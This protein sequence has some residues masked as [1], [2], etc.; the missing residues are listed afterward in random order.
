MEVY[1]MFTKVFQP[2][3]LHT[4]AKNGE[5][6]EI[7]KLIKCNF[8]INAY[9]LNY[10]P[11]QYSLINLDEKKHLNCN[12]CAVILLENGAD[13]NAEYKFEYFHLKKIIQIFVWGGHLSKVRLLAIYGASGENIQFNPKQP[14]AEKIFKETEELYNLK[15]K[16]ETIIGQQ[17]ASKTETRQAY[18]GLYEIWHTLANKENDDVFKKHYQHKANFYLEFIHLPKEIISSIQTVSQE[19]YISLRQRNTKLSDEQQPLI[20]YQI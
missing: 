8:D 17:S 7:N 6:Q 14:E 12:K 18:Q 4:A 5:W 3:A 20:K 16:L 2:H 10:T 11:L 13:V 19:N 1:R 15:K 9:Y